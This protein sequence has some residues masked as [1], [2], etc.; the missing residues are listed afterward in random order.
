MNGRL[1]KCTLWRVLVNADI[2]TSHTIAKDRISNHIRTL[3]SPSQSC[4]LVH[5]FNPF[6]CYLVVSPVVLLQYA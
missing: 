1:I 3:T 6:G 5:R 2:Y 4:S